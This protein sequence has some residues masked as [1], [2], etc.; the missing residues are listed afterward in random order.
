MACVAASTSPASAASRNLRTLVFSDDLTA[1]LRCRAFSFCLFRLICDLMF[2]TRE[3]RLDA[4]LVVGGRVTQASRE[5]RTGSGAHP[6]RRG[7]IS[8]LQALAQTRCLAPG[9]GRAAEL[10]RQRWLAGVTVQSC[11]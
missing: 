11:S 10:D 7:R 8:Q 3:P 4:G 2:A 6:A 9:T 1:L 5:R